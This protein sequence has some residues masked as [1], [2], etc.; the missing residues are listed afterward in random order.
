MVLFAYNMS[1]QFTAQYKRV[2]EERNKN[3]T[4]IG[5]RKTPHDSLTIN[6]ILSE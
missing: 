2:Q 6:Q 4:N 3:Q 5:N 1:I